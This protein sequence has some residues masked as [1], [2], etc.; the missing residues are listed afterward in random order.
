MG[1]DFNR[2]EFVGLG[3]AATAG[4]LL[5]CAQQKKVYNLKPFLDQA[6]DGIEIKA[7]LVGC[8]GR[9]T[10]AAINFLNSGSD[11]CTE[12]IPHAEK[13]IFDRSTSDP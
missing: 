7:G 3:A 1:K 5:G 11:T 6:P 4:I 8:G 10:G 9:G 12:R 13:S 2:R